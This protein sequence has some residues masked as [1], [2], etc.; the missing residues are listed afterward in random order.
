MSATTT[1]PQHHHQHRVPLAATLAVAGVIAAAGVVGV[2][3][4]L[5]TGGDLSLPEVGGPRPLPVRIANKYVDRV[6]AAAESD[7]VVAEQFSKVGTL[8][9]APTRLLRPA[10]IAR[11]ATANL[12]RRRGDHAATASAAAR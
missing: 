9:D 8:I 3:W 11:V 5:A 4:Q 1:T 2:A 12:R 7:T 10:V 6:L